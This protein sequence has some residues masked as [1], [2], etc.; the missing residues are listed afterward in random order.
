VS[1]SKDAIR[2]LQQHDWPDNVR[3]L[4]NVVERVLILANG[5]VIR[6]SDILNAIQQ[7]IDY[8]TAD[9][10]ETDNERREL[11]SVLERAGWDTTMAAKLLRV[12]RATIYRRMEK[13]G[14]PA[15]RQKRA[16]GTERV[17]L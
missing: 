7:G 11:L 15:R 2:A 10:R 4:N 16:N 6:R 17:I 8:P 12:S 14:V 13:L 3:G 1:F 5:P 9:D